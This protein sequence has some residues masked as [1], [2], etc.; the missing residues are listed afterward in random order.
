[1]SSAALAAKLFTSK[2]PLASYR[3]AG[4]DARSRRLRRNGIGS[5]AGR[6]CGAGWTASA[7][8]RARFQTKLFGRFSGTMDESDFSGPYITVYGP[9]LHR[10]GRRPA[11]GSRPE[12][13]RFPCQSARMP[14][15]DDAEPLGA[16][17]IALGRVAFCRLESIGPPNEKS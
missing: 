6:G 9:R 13:S 10:A 12:I 3:R 16:R 4:M 15:L 2:F 8:G 11:G 1:M 17:V 14:G 5:A 7:A